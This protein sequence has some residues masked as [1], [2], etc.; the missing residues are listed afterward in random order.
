VRKLNKLSD[1]SRPIDLAPLCNG[2]G[3]QLVRAMQ[4]SKGSCG[5]RPL[6]CNWSAVNSCVQMVSG[7]DTSKSWP[8]DF[9]HGFDPGLD[10][11]PASE[12]APRRAISSL[13]GSTVSQ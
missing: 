3:E 8:H 9:T 10:G 2:P 4:K 12:F 7:F 5:R 13:Q 6:S 11:T 1:N